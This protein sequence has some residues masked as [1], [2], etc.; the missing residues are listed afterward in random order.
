MWRGMGLSGSNM[1]RD[2]RKGQR[3]MRMNG[4]RYLVAL[5]MGSISRTKDLEW[6]RFSGLYWSDYLR[7]LAV[8]LWKPKRGHLL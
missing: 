1:G 6:R 4:N 3:T 8:V 7:L 2:R 5:G